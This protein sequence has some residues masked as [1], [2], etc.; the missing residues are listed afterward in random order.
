MIV[1]HFLNWA[2]SCI[3]KRA[4]FPIVDFQ[5]KLLVFWNQ[6]QS[7]LFGLLESQLLIIQRRFLFKKWKIF[8]VYIN[9]Y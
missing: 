9:I 8:D 7:S 2:G 1:H 6:L 4:F 3:V 5:N